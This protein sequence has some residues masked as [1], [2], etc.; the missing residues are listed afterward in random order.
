MQ[1]VNCKNEINIG[2]I[3]CPYCHTN[4]HSFDSKPYSNCG[5]DGPPADALDGLAAIGAVTLCF[6]PVV[7]LGI[8]GV[9]GM[10]MVGGWLWKK[11]KG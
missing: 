6:N 4:P 8:I 3:V 7:G 9:A 10:G 2:G 1:C 5:N 11:I